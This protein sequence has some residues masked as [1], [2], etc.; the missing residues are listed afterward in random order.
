VGLFILIAV[1]GSIVF[2]MVVYL[3]MGFG[4]TLR[5]W[6]EVAHP[7]SAGLHSRHY[8]MFSM[9]LWCAKAAPQSSC[10]FW[11]LTILD[12]LS[13]WRWWSGA[14]HSSYRRI[15]LY[16]KTNLPTSTRRF[17]SAC[18]IKIRKPNSF[19]FFRYNHI[20]PFEH[21]RVRLHDGRHQGSH[22]GHSSKRSKEDK[23]KIA[24]VNAA[25]GATG[26][27]SS[28]T[29][30]PSSESQ[31]AL[32]SATTSTNAPEE[33]RNTLMSVDR[34]PI[35]TPSSLGMPPPSSIPMT[36]FYSQ[37]AF[38][39]PLS[40]PMTPFGPPSSNLTRGGVPMTHFYPFPR[41]SGGGS[42]AYFPAFPPS[43]TSQISPIPEDAPVLSP[44]RLETRT[45]QRSGG[46]LSPSILS[47]LPRSPQSAGPKTVSPLIMPSYTPLGSQR[48]MFNLTLPRGPISS[49]GTSIP[50][51]NMTV[52]PPTD[53]PCDPSPADDYVNAS[54]VQPLGTRKRYIATQG[55]LPATFVDF[56]T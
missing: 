37:S 40:M 23:K 50:Q 35:C 19:R 24:S 39:T 21:A 33:D 17:F 48:E 2:F 41:S 28:A 30:A 25:A 11:D 36:P 1:F 32:P 9:T 13:C 4:S 43:E 34:N 20:W 15:F 38:H 31:L 14:Y 27:E 47:T 54:Y 45:Q 3:R 55:P 8:L 5:H 46:F 7:S 6:R 44:P 52:V 53:K 49:A 18:F 42:D 22:P 51:F 10:S 56:W 16:L 12:E 26:F 29:V